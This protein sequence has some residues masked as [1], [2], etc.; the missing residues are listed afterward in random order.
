MVYQGI[1]V[2]DE[3]FADLFLVE[4]PAGIAAPSA[5][6]CSH[7][8]RARE[9]ARTIS[10]SPGVH[11]PNAMG[12]EIVKCGQS[13][14]QRPT[15]DHLDNSALPLPSDGDGLIASTRRD[16]RSPSQPPTYESLRPRAISRTGRDEARGDGAWTP[17][18]FRALPCLRGGG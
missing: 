3:S 4:F 6:K 2:V 15:S 18:L 1:S 14:R 12:S 5:C 11:S 9:S 7:Q 10:W 17:V 8:I 13:S 16:A